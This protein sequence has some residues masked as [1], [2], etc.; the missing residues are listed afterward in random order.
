MTIYSK[1]DK[2]SYWS[3]FSVCGR[4]RRGVS[5]LKLPSIGATLENAVTNLKKTF[6]DELY[7]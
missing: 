4:G 5:A 3:L 6:K 2:Q 7:F 1:D